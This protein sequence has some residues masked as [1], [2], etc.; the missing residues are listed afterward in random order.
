VETYCLA[1]PILCSNVTLQPPTV[2]SNL[3]HP[4]QGGITSCAVL[5]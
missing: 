3:M 5:R 2:N 4:A 1:G